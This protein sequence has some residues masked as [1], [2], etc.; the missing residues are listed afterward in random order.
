MAYFLTESTELNVTNAQFT[1]LFASFLCARTASF[2]MARHKNRE[3]AAHFCV[4]L[5]RLSPPFGFH[6]C[7]LF[8]E[9]GFF[10]FISFVWCWEPA[11]AATTRNVAMC[12]AMAA[13]SIESKI[14]G[15]FFLLEQFR[16]RMN[17]RL[18]LDSCTLFIVWDVVRCRSQHQIHKY[19][20]IVG[21]GVIISRLAS[22]YIALALINTAADVHAICA[23]YICDICVYTT[24]C[25]ALSRSLFKHN[26]MLCIKCCLQW[27]QCAKRNRKGDFV[28]IWYNWHFLL[29]LTA[30]YSN[31]IPTLK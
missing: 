10:P 13:F 30:T 11:T 20:L 25:T 27:W 26:K 6:I 22:V 1:I 4:V 15:I 9:I 29:S 19:L 12:S 24:Q 28:F 16:F 23:M 2:Q 3:I 8:V 5:E 14:D 7:A 18:R 31:S 17:S 21:I